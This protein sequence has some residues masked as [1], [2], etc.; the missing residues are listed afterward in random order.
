LLLECDFPPLAEKAL[1][2][3]SMFSGFSSNEWLKYQRK[4][5][6]EVDVVGCFGCSVC[7]FWLK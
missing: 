1:I 4:M 7:G 2:D 5:L 6:T 3:L